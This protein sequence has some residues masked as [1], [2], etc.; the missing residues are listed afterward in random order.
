MK[1]ARYQT[2]TGIVYGAEAADGRYQRFEGDPLISMALADTYDEAADVQPLCPVARPRIFGVGLNYVSHIKEAGKET[3]DFPMLFMKPDTAA[4]GPEEAVIYP[5]EGQNVHYEAEL[6]VIIG[7]QARRVSET[8]ALDCVF[9]YTC[10]ND[11]S[12]RVIQFK[13]MDTGCLL[14]GKGFDTFNP[15]GPVIVTGLDPSNLE[16]RMR[17][18]GETRQEINT[19]D[20][21]F[22]VPQLISYMSEAMT[23]LPGDVIITGTPAG[24]GP[25]VP[26]DIMEVEIPEIGILRNPVVAEGEG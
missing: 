17:V 19:S 7:K 16:L 22:S 25:V 2:E 11:I 26:G 6:A 21:L 13:E 5:F 3:P 10:A 14:I 24:V 23:L 9:G 1:I 8:E 12:E 18:N 15:L 4:C 20:L